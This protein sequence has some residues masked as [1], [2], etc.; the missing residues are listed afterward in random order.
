VAVIYLDSSA[1]VKLVVEE[2]ETSALIKELRQG[3]R[4]VT[5]RVG[6]IEVGRAAGRHGGVDAPRLRQ[7]INGLDIIEL[8]A[9][10]ASTASSIGP[11]DLRTLD[12]IHLASALALRE[13]LS[14]FVS[15]DDRLNAGAKLHGL[16]ITSPGRLAG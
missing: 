14:Q 11:S 16:A 2:S 3:D 1:I 9:A 4:H 13:E 7:V 15:Y 5:S 10:I 6:L 12:A 8:T